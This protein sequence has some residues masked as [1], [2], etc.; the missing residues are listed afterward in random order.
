MPVGAA[1]LE[2]I[3]LGETVD[4]KEKSENAS[5]AGEQFKQSPNSQGPYNEVAGSDVRN[6]NTRRV[7]LLLPDLGEG[8]TEGELVRWLVQEGEPVQVD[9]AVA[10][11]MTDKATV[12]VPSPYSGILRQRMITEGQKVPVKSVIA[13]L[14]LLEDPS[15]QIQQN[16]K[17]EPNK[18][19]DKNVENGLEES[20]LSVKDKKSDSSKD[21]LL[22]PADFRVLATPYTRRLAR[23]LGI[24]INQVKPTGLNG[25][26][27]RDDVLRAYEQMKAQTAGDR[28]LSQVTMNASGEGVKVSQQESVEIVPLVGIRRKIAENMKLSY[29]S[30]AHFT[31]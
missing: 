24:D 20:F 22:P 25:R 16:T 27:T 12:E 31:L 19:I 14:D 30:L 23:E 15:S 28:G 11:F 29:S 21:Q 6:P 26:V 17:D 5:K 1:I 18:L 2:L 7:E 3:N 4:D 10:E 13:I 8:V 9:Q